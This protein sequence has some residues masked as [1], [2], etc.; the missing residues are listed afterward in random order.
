MAS[1]VAGDPPWENFA[2][3]GDELA[4]PCY[5]LVG[6]LGDA[7]DAEAASLAAGTALFFLGALFGR[8][9]S[10]GAEK[11]LSCRWRWS[12]D[13]PT[14]VPK[15]GTAPVMHHAEGLHGVRLRA[16]EALPLQRE[17]ACDTV[18]TPE[19]GQREVEHFVAASID[20]R[21]AQIG[22]EPEGLRGVDRR[23]H[24]EFLTGGDDVDKGGTIVR[25]G[26]GK[27]R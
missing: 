15:N 24:G 5:I 13:D 2:A 25:K 21:L 12:I 19:V 11:I 27:C 6:Q 4:E 9:C 18:L 16:Y 3:L 10:H 22:S 7:I 17:V 23:R 1:A 26:A 14:Q 20:D 8:G